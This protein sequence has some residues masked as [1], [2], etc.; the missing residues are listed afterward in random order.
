MQPMPENVEAAFQAF[1][2]EVRHRLAEIRAMISDVAADDPRIGTVTE[3]LKWGEPAYLTEATGSG[4]TIRLGWPRKRPD[5]AAIYFICHTTL[6]D[7]FRE[8]FGGMFEYETNRAVLLPVTGDI[9]RAPLEFMLA[10][11]LAYHLR[12]RGV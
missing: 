10:M 12:P 8:R 11:A 1:P 9:D 4:S 5:R 2:P 7:S 6:V 3:T